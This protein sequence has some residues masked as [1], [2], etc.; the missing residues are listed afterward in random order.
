MSPNGFT[1]VVTLGISHSL[2]PNDEMVTLTATAPSGITVQYKPSSPV[3]LPGST[4]LNVTLVVEAGATAALGNDS[5]T[6]KGVSGTNSQSATFTVRVVQYRVVME[7]NQF[8]PPTLNVTV[9]GTV[10]WQNLDGPLAGCAGPGGGSGNGDHNVVFTTLPGANSSTISQF[11]I[12]SYTF[13]TPGSYFYYSSLNTDESMNGTIN[14][15]AAAGGIGNVAAMPVFSNLKG[16]GPQM[17][18]A[19]PIAGTESEPFGAVDEPSPVTADGSASSGTFVLSAH[20][21]SLSSL[22]SD[23]G[24][25]GLLGLIVSCAAM[26]MVALGKRSLTAISLGTRMS[27]SSLWARGGATQPSPTSAT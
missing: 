22:V 21:P 11:Q 20:T 1:E 26:V 4:P 2:A 17:P 14:V 10:Y 3:D 8:L 25:V 23:V 16:S 6:I 18:S 5:I 13:T 24:A 12:Y 7:D 27:A 19:V 9:G 15:L